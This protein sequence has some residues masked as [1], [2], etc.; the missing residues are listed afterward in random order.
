MA[1]TLGHYLNNVKLGAVYDPPLPSAAPRFSW[2]PE[3]GVPTGAAQRGELHPGVALAF[4]RVTSTTGGSR[5]R[6]RCFFAA[7]R[8]SCAGV[9]ARSEMIVNQTAP[10]LAGGRRAFLGAPHRNRRA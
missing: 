6:Q 9:T 1:D 5:G 10:L 4:R 8:S 7:R 3:G 2:L